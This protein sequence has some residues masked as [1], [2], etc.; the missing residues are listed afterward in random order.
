MSDEAHQHEDS[1]TQTM[2]DFSGYPIH[3][4]HSFIQNFASSSLFVDTESLQNQID[5]LATFSDTLAPSVTRILYTKKDVLARRVW[6]GPKGQLQTQ[7][8]F[9]I[10]VLKQR[11]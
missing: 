2:E 4:P 1:T 11:L 7:W 5:E 6:S 10:E 3:E 8:M 9:L